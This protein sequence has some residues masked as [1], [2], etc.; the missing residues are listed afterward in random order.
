MRMYPLPV[1]E[2]VS[3][4]PVYENVSYLPDICPVPPHSLELPPFP[5]SI[6]I[7]LIPCQVMWQCY[8]FTCLPFLPLFSAALIEALTSNI[9]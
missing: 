7:M 4:L 6:L 5:P 8:S 1:Y 2:N 9:A 3:S